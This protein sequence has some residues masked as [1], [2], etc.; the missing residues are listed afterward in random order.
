LGLNCRAQGSTWA[1]HVSASRL[2]MV[3]SLSC[4]HSI[5]RHVFDAQHQSGCS[6]TG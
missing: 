2:R 5:V 1:S 4:N 6:Q 3:S